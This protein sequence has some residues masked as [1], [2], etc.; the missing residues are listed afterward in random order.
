MTEQP[1]C[2]AVR[3]LVSVSGWAKHAIL[4]EFT[5]VEARNANFV[6]FEE[7]ASPRQGRVVGAGHRPGRPLSRLAQ[8]RAPHLVCGE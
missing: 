4:H 3:K 6:N 5:S 8:R 7:T 1:G 2:V